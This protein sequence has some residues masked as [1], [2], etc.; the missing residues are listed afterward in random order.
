MFVFAILSCLSHAALWSPAE[1]GLSSLMFYFFIVLLLF[2]TFPYGILGQLWYLIVSL[3][4]LC[5]RPDFAHNIGNLAQA[6]N[7]GSYERVQMGN[8]IKEIAARIYSRIL[9]IRSPI[10]LTFYFEVPV[11]RIKGR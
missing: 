5:L 3:P 8:L 2:V 6:S 1:N 7:Y 10:D 4:D 11:V 9:L